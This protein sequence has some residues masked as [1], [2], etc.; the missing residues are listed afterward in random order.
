MPFTESGI[1]PD[2]IMNP[3]AIPSRMTIS[4]LIECMAAKVG[5]IQGKFIDGTPFNNYDVR[6]LPKLLKKIRL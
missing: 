5:S 2:I 3:H 1:I 4:Q 6:E